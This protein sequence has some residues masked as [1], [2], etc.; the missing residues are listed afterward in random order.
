MSTMGIIFS[1]IYDNNMGELTAMRTSA[2]IPFGSRY[3][4]VDFVLSNMA[5]SGIKSI[6]IITKYNYQSLMDHLGN[7]EEWDLKL[8]DGVR[9]LPPYATG[10]TG[11]YHGKL[12]ALQTAMP[13][14][15]RSDAEYVVLSDTTVLCAINFRLVVEEH[16]RS[17]CDITVIAKAGVANG[18]K[19]QHAAFKLGEDGEIEDMAVD[20][21][22]PEDYL[23]G[24]SMF[25]I[26]R[27][28]LIEIIRESVPRGK[29]H[30]ERDYLLPQYNEGKLKIH[31]Y[32]FHNVVMFNDSTVEYYKNS[33]RLLDEDVRHGLYRSEVPIY[34]KVRDDMPAKYGLNSYATNCLVADGCVIDGEVENCVLFRGVKIGK[35]AKVRNCVI[36]QDTVI[37]ANSRL[38]YV[39]ADKNVEIE[40]NR[41]LM[42]YQTYPVY[43]AKESKV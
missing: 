7:C 1:N 20:Y 21:R 4:Q 18:E 22:A 32:P 11:A 43:I 31:V 26:A 5:N 17:G 15:E 34:T 39:V 35:G 37:G 42:G 38:D 25:V 2:S 8:G 19:L 28:K 24:M 41:T 36:M 33:M 30:L 23:V 3:R 13:V 40:E 16:I 10:H 27:K 9:F 14:L 29:Y 6:G 12:E